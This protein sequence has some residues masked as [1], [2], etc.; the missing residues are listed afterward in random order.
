[1]KNG[2]NSAKNHMKIDQ[3]I[4]KNKTWK[5]ITKMRKNMQKIMKIEH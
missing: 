3:K 2:K 4:M 1:M 5:I